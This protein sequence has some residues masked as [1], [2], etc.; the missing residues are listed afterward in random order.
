MNGSEGRRGS[1][2]WLAWPDA[3]CGEA[4]LREPAAFG[5]LGAGP[6]RPSLSDVCRQS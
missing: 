6:W 3:K 5:N 4:E 2:R 1:T